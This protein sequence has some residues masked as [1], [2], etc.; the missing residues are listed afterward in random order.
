[1]KKSLKRRWSPWNN[2]PLMI[3]APIVV[4]IVFISSNLVVIP[5]V[6]GYGGG[7][8]YI[9]TPSMP[10][11]T[12]GQVTATVDDGGKTTLTTVNN[13]IA[14]VEL[15]SNA[16]NANTIIT[17][18]PIPRTF[19]T[20]SKAVAAVPATKILVGSYVYNFTATAGT[21]AVTTFN[22]SI[23]LT[24]T[25][26]DAQIAGLNES[27]F[28]V[29]YW[30]ESIQE[31]I[32]LPT[33]VNA[34]TNILTVTTTHFTNFTILGDKSVTG[35]ILF[36]KDLIKIAGKSAVYWFYGN[37]LH[38][39]PHL[40]VYLS[41][42]LPKDFSTVKTVSLAELNSYSEGDAVP[43]RDGSL[44]RGIS[45][46]LYGK[47]ASAVFYVEDGKLR[48][49]KSAA[50]YQALFNDSKWTK[51]TWVPDNLLTKF[52][53]P[54]GDLIESSATHPNGALVKYSDSSIIYLIVNGKKSSFT[55]WQ[56]F[57]DNG[58]KQE[59]IL[60]IPKTEIYSDAEQIGGLE[61]G[62]TVPTL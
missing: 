4:L 7:G 22:R 11:T 42:G 51:V 10:Q 2:V 1:M 5:I 61:E 26:A 40:N 25:Y 19:S 20:V 44:F 9:Y 43:F 6:F 56:V 57:A 27:T 3:M 38:V 62:L 32:A 17:I 55:F 8:G 33:T 23:T 46:S 34:E 54:L 18:A 48:P 58:Y 29:Y 24:F 35:E 53:Y 47:S 28:K 37:K 60:T 30:Q 21:T 31:W 59:T 13:T 45:K 41:W 50:I 39:F 15:P 12:T 52:S 49:I 36:N 16:V 14:T